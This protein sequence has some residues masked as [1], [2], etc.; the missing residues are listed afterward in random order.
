VSES[1][2]ELSELGESGVELLLR[3]EEMLKL[4]PK[5][6]C[7][8]GVGQLGQVQVLERDSYG[9]IGQPLVARVL[10]SSACHAFGGFLRDVRREQCG[11]AAEAL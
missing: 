5:A 9:Q 1:V 10:T 3:A 6:L 4:A 7:G 2:P 8:D 11:I